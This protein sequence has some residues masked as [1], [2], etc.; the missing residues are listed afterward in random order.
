[1]I[2]TNEELQS[3]DLFVEVEKKEISNRFNNKTFKAD[4]F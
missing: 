3:K 2:T 4:R 1:M